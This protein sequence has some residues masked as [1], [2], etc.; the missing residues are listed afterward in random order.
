MRRGFFV[1]QKD[2]YYVYEKTKLLPLVNAGEEL[3][4]T[5][6]THTLSTIFPLARRF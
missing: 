2:P 5:T 4:L 1:S 6:S 3:S